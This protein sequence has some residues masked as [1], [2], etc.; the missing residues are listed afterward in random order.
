M[1]KEKVKAGN[2]K[3]FASRKTLFTLLKLRGLSSV[4]FVEDSE[5]K[6]FVDV[7]TYK[8]KS[9]AITE[10]NYIIAK[11]IEGWTRQM[12]NMGYTLKK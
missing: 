9:G 5:D 11:D 10:T 6:W 4:A 8:T 1:K 2:I 7:M 3:D 12:G